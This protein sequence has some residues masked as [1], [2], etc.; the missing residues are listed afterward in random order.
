MRRYTIKD[1]FFAD[2]DTEEKAY[3]FGFLLAD[4]WLAHTKRYVAVAVHEQDRA[5][6]DFLRGAL[7]SDAPISTK[8]RSSGHGVA[9]SLLLTNFCSVRLVADLQRHGLVQ[10][11]SHGARLPDL[12]PAIMRHLLR[13]LFDGDG[14]IGPRQFFL[15]GSEAILSD[16]V[17]VS[18]G[19][20]SLRI[21]YN[22]GYPRIAGGRKDAGFLDWLYSPCAFALPRKLAAYEESWKRPGARGSFVRSGVLDL[23]VEGSPHS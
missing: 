8:V 13:G 20:A 14:H 3:A 1:D 18:D 10:N 5:V 16:V 4:G 9:K 2:L 22:K 23:V 12:P 11:K 19:V 15:T 17:R 7:G 21:G 6:L